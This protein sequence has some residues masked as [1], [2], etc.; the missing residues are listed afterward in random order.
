MEYDQ[1]ETLLEEHPVVDAAHFYRYLRTILPKAAEADA[2]SDEHLHYDA[3]D[4]PLIQKIDRLVR[5]FEHF[6][7]GAYYAFHIW[8][9]S[10]SRVFRDDKKRCRVVQIQRA[11][12]KTLAELQR[13][14]GRS[15]KH[16]SWSGQNEDEDSIQWTYPDFYDYAAAVR[17]LSVAMATTSGCPRSSNSDDDDYCYHM[18]NLSTLEFLHKQAYSEVRAKVFLTV[19]SQLPV[20]LTEQVFE[21][22]LQAEGV[23]LDPRVREIIRTP[24]SPLVAKWSGRDYEEKM[25]IKGPYRCSR[26][27]KNR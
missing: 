22:A 27:G 21:L 11:C 7:G 8:V 1:L 16:R 20:E 9:L 18:L 14:A 25:K 12:W 26:M 19:G 13:Y 17:E 5:E 2:T 4:H 10:L 23:P 6:R 3:Q 24:V 15:G